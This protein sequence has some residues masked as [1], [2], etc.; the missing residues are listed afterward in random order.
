MKR[1]L[2]VTAAA[3]LALAAGGAA[4]LLLP[5]Q[6]PEAK[7][8]DPR[9]LAPL[10]NLATARLPGNSSSS[11]TGTVGARVQSNLGFRVPGKIVER[12]VDVGEQVSAGQP[13]MRLDETD[14]RLALTA[15]RNA[16]IAAQ[17]TFVQAKADEKRFA[18]LVKTDP[19]AEPR[20]KGMSLVIADKRDGFTVS[21]KLEKL[22]YK[23]IDSAELVF[24][25][26]E[27]PADQLIGEE[28]GKG[29][30]QA[31]GGLELGRINVAARGV[32][33]AEGALE[34]VN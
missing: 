18:V 4:A 17:A 13:L 7:A 12:F 24:N 21:R 30:Y 27:L 34:L 8:A 25:D 10:V 1:K 32:G 14:L 20:H 22:G 2:V 9:T 3:V 33:I 31:T 26:Y 16:V 19:D 29:F 15:K 23:S 5:A 11:F 28:E 6:A